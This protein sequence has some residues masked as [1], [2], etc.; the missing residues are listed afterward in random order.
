MA[1]LSGNQL[2]D[3]D[4]CHAFLCALTSLPCLGVEIGEDKV[5]IFATPN[6]GDVHEEDSLV[7][8]KTVMSVIKD[9]GFY[10]DPLFRNTPS[11]DRIDGVRIWLFQLPA[12]KSL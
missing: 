4:L 6:K 9:W 1:K 10:V 2:F 3:K 11:G 7:A 12:F 5:Y 8:M